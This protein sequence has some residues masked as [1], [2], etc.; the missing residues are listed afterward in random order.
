MSCGDWAS[1]HRSLPSQTSSRIRF[2]PGPGAVQ[3]PILNPSH[4]NGPSA[5]RLPLRMRRVS[6]WPGTAFPGGGTTS[7]AGVASYAGP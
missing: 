3:G 4:R 1:S 7:G 2:A 5:P 6:R